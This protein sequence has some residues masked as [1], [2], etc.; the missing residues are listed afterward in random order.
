MKAMHKLLGALSLLAALVLVLPHSAPLFS[1][2]FPQ[3]ERPVYVQESFSWLLAQHVL[4]AFVSS[5]VAVLVG[6]AVGVGVTRRV[7]QQF[8]PLVESVVAVSQ[9]IPPVAVLALAVPV[10]GFGDE[11][12]GNVAH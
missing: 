7:G 11:F 1:A 6:T 8:K 10:V 5:F 12:L 4:L 9:A 3:L 2:L